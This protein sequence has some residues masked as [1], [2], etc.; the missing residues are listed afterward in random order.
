VR[1]EV[2][3]TRQHACRLAYHL[4]PR[5]A[6]DLVGEVAQLSWT[7]AGRLRSARLELPPE[8]S[9]TVHRGET[10]PSLGWYSLGFGRKEPTST[11]L[12]SGFAGG[13]VP[14]LNT[15]VRFT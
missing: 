14:P 1:D 9:W 5:I 11:L 7:S 8:L 12:G 4:G 10:T 6:A 13:G 2:T 15:L 3:S